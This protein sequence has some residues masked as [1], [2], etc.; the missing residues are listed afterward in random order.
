MATSCSLKNILE[1]HFVEEQNKEIVIVDDKT[2]KEKIYLIRGQ[3]VM[4]DTD[5]AEIYGY[6]TRAFNQQVRNN[7]EKFDDDFMFRLDKIEL[8]DLRSN[9]LTANVSPKSRALPYVFT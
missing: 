2:I 8:E 3:R 4:L 6:S 7:I 1:V 9:F 5:L